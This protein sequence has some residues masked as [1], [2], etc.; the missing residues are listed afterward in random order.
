MRFYNFLYLVWYVGAIFLALS[1]I[2]SLIEKNLIYAALCGVLSLFY[3]LI[4]SLYENRFKTSS[5]QR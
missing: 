5:L 2:P 4:G 3:A 1:T